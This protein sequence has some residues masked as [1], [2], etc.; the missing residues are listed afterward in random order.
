LQFWMRHYLYQMLRLEIDKDN[1][2]G[3][4]I[5]LGAN[6]DTGPQSFDWSCFIRSRSIL[7]ILRRMATVAE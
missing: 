3:T 4:N 2:Q 7:R 1:L 6:G 5:V